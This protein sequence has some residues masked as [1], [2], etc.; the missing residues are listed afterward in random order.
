MCLYFTTPN[1]ESHLN[2]LGPLSIVTHQTFLRAL[3]LFIS[4]EMSPGHLAFSTQGSISTYLLRKLW[5][6]IVNNCVMR[7]ESGGGKSREMLTCWVSQ[8]TS[9][10]QWPSESFNFLILLTVCVSFDC[11]ISLSQFNCIML[12][13][14]TT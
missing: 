13:N 1:N 7:A 11:V 3:L 14:G 6:L 10:K 2:K 5:F 12:N 9:E 8:V 4:H